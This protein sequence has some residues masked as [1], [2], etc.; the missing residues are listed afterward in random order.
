MMEKGSYFQNTK[1]NSKS[2]KFFT[3]TLFIK[4]KEKKRMPLE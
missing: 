3:I 4:K 2:L 1:Y